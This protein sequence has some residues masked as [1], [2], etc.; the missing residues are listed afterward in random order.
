MSNDV[1]DAV[2]TWVAGSDPIHQKKRRFYSD[3]SEPKNST[4]SKRFEEGEDLI[5]CLRSIFKYAPWIRNIYILTDAQVPPIRADLAEEKRVFIIDHKTVF[6]GFENYLPTF[7]SL[8]IEAFLWRIEGLANQFIYFNDDFGLCRPVSPELFFQSSKVVLCGKWREAEGSGGSALR[9]LQNAIT[10][11]GHDS[12]RF[13][14]CGHVPSSLSRSIFEQLFNLYGNSFVSNLG[15][16]FREDKNFLPVGLHNHYALDRDRAVVSSYPHVEIHSSTKQGSESKIKRLAD[17]ISSGKVVSY[18]NN[19][20]LEMKALFP[21]LYD[22]FYSG[23]QDPLSF[24][25][26]AP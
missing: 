20:S 3:G 10:I 17:K 19:H 21:D 9:H 7:N 16:R 4:A 8:A 18:C 26:P 11:L 25:I 2:I 15:S 1:V 14:K 13:F 23:L 12:R 6:R 5:F 22:L 24:E